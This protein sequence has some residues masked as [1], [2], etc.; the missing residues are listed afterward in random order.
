[1]S[2]TVI[3]IRTVHGASTAV[4]WSGVR[5]L[6]IDRSTEAGGLGLG[7]NGG[8]LLLLAIGACYTNDLYREAAKQ[9]LAIRSVSLE[10][11]CK[12][13]GDPIRAQEVTFAPTVE[14]D[15]PLAEIDT[16]IGHTDRVAEVHNSLRLGTQVT[17]VSPRRS[18][19]VGDE[20]P[21]KSFKRTA[22]LRYAQPCRR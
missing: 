18:R 1:M 6:T 13:G 5:T 2:E 8:E 3:N 19:Q 10:V 15:A 7:Y 16:L 14:A 21:N 17:L 4:G 22:G 20:S 12:W 11:R 9:G